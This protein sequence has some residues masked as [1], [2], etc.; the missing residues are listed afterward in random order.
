M[1]FDTQ[2]CIQGLKRHLGNMKSMEK[3]VNIMDLK[4][5]MCHS[6]E[7]VGLNDTKDKPP[8]SMEQVVN[9]MELKGQMCHSKGLRRI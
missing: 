6:K 2:K 8:R 3:V 5:Q 4:G 7:N 9:I 1:K